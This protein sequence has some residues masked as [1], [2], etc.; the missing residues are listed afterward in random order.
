MST[1]PVTFSS[2][3]TVL[4]TGVRTRP[5]P[6]LIS[7]ARC[8]DTRS[9]HRNGHALRPNAAPTRSPRHRQRA[10]A[11]DVRQEA[12]LK[13]WSRLDQFRPGN[14]EDNTDDFRAWLARI[15]GNTSIDTLAPAPRRQTSLA[16]RTA[17]QFRRIA[18]HFARD[19]DRRSR[20]AVR[21]PR[22]GPQTSRRDPSAPRRS[23]PGLPAPRRHALLDARSRRS[24]LDFRRRRPPPPC[25]AHAADSAK[26]WSSLSSQHLVRN[27]AHDALNRHRRAIS[28][29]TR[30]RSRYSA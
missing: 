22:N 18:R 29:P 17:R 28:R 24:P 7:R 30:D 9:L 10:D 1:A 27:C 15:A 12:L 21:A 4:H 13:A 26:K 16:R 6:T 20:R 5:Q 2:E 3:F 11:E 25:S 23:A 19:A 8:G 14:C